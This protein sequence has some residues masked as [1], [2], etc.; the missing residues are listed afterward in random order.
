MNTA[1]LYVEIFFIVTTLMT[2]WIFFKATASSKPTLWLMIS[3]LIIQAGLGLAGFYLNT[4]TIPPRMIALIVPPMLL[5]AG[6]FFTQK[7]KQYIDSIDTSLLTL[8]HTVR[9][10][11]EITLFWLFTAKMVP[12][13]MTFEGR[14][15]DILS[16]ISAPIVYYF[17]YK[18]KLF[19]KSI[20]IVWNCLCL[21]LLLNIVITAILSVPTTFQQFSFAEPNIGVM[22]FPFVWLPCFIVPVVLFSHLVTL[23]K[24]VQ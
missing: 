6:M 24:L 21:G 9:I 17:G 3:W 7:G 11:V 15:F 12:E 14:N 10:P 13:L 4:T 1:P 2:L 23:R 16:G 19:G 8:L 18:Q 22:Y 20:L 5:I